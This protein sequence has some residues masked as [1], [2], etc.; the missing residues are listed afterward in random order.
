MH[1]CE[2]KDLKLKT[3]QYKQNLKT[4]TKSIDTKIHIKE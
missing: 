4:K 1:P 2:E 3:R